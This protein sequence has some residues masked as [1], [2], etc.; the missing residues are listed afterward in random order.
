[1]LDKIEVSEM[2]GMALILSPLARINVYN[3]LEWPEHKLN[4]IKAS[5]DDI[6]AH[7][8]QKVTKKWVGIVLLALIFT[9]S[10][11]IVFPS[12]YY[13]FLAGERSHQHLGNS[14]SNSSNRAIGKQN[15]PI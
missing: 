15:T 13:V 5:V 6:L 7:H 4:A 10:L 14:T 1:M 9:L 3:E 12:V 8:S 2:G 11:L